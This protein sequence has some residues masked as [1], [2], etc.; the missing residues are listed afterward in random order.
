MALTVSLAVGCSPGENAPS[1]NAQPA[2]PASAQKPAAVAAVPPVDACTLLSKADVEG[3]AGKSVLAGRK[4]DAG[5]L[6]MC[7]FDD[8]TA[9]QVG[10]RGISQVLTL[11]VMTGQEGAYV[12]GPSAQA[13][14]SLEIARKNSASDETVSGLGDVAYWDKILRTLNVASGRYYVTVGVESRDDSL[15]VAKAAAAK[16]LAKLPK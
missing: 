11:A 4:E 5:P 14:D 6:V 3:A 1:A 13:K 8:P 9:P 16:A 15:T 10:G 12:K 7:S 2:A